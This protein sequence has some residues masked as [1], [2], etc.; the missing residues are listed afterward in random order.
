MIK[1][2]NLKSL[3]DIYKFLESNKLDWYKIFESTIFN[4]ET[5]F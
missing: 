3:D 4:K 1:V 2:G 5:K